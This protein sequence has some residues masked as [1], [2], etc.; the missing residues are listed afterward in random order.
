MVFNLYLRYNS[1]NGEATVPL[2]VNVDLDSNGCSGRVRI[3]ESETEIRGLYEVVSNHNQL[4]I[5]YDPCGSV[6]LIQGTNAIVRMPG[7]SLKR[8]T[9]RIK[10]KDFYAVNLVFPRGTKI[11]IR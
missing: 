11:S 3:G 10:D 5:R 1:P 2:E 6:P 8:K 7:V 4:L 9:K